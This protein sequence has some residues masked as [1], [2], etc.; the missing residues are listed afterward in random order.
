MNKK[1]I[2]KK[3]ISAK[4]IKS[5]SP[6][7]QTYIQHQ[8]SR[9]IITW[10]S[11]PTR[12]MRTLTQQLLLLQFAARNDRYYERDQQTPREDVVPGR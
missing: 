10:T 3:L 5:T 1:K 9:V 4:G 8:L 6:P 2:K 12:A 7:S 11:A